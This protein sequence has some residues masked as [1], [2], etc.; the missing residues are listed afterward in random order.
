MRAWVIKRGKKYLARNDHKGTYV[1]DINKAD[2][3][4]TKKGVQ[5]DLMETETAVEVDVQIKEISEV[6]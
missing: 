6:K 1:S 4:A 2:L 5:A 3:Y